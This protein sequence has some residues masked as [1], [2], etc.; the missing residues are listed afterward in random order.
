MECPSCRRLLE[1]K[2]YRGGITVDECLWCRG[3]WFDP[4]ELETYRAALASLRAEER[5]PSLT[6]ELAAED[7]ESNCPRCK[8]RTLVKGKISSIELQKC[9]DCRGVFV[10]G[11]QI[12]ILTEQVVK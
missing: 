2:S 8:E 3:V 7:E 10:S 11:E 1:Q 4:G 6:F 5:Y 9:R 12:A